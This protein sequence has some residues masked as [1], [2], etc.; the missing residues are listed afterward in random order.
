MPNRQCPGQD[1]RY[2]KPEDVYE[3]PCVHCG[4]PIE[5]FKIDLRRLCPHCGKYM[6]N[7]KNDMSCAAWCKHAAECLDEVGSTSNQPTDKQD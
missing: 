1:T 5:F 7:P 4:Q 2:W 6:V 3:A